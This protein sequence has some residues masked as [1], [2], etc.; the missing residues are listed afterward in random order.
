MTTPTI[1]EKTQAAESTRFAFS[2]T[3]AS[4][5]P[6]GA[7][8]NQTFGPLSD[9]GATPRSEENAGAPIQSAK[10][11]QSSKSSRSF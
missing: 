3:V 4:L 2:I 9:P 1:E 7:K 8:L 6:I 10:Q 5:R 11:N